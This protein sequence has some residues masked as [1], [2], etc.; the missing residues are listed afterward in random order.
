MVTSADQIYTLSREGL[1]AMWQALAGA[2]HRVVGPR[3]RDGAIVYDVLEGSRELPWGWTAQQGPAQYT[4][5]RRL[6]GAAFGWAV[7]PQSLRRFVQPA[8]ERLWTAVGS[9]DGFTIEDEPLGDD[10][11]LAFFGVRACDLAALAVQERVFIG[12][13]F[14]DVRALARRRGIFVVAVD[15]TEPGGSCFCASMQTGPGVTSGHDV[16]L[17]ERA[18]GAG[19]PVYLARAGTE[20][21][22]AWLA[23]LDF[24]EAG[25]EA[26]AE[27][28]AAVEEA[29]GRMGRSM[30]DVDLRAVIAARTE[31]RYWEEIGARCLACSNC[32]LVCPTCFCMTVEDVTDL[33]GERS[34]RH[35]RW[36]SCFGLDFSYLHGGAV[37]RAVGARYRQWMSHKLSTWWDQFGTSGCVGCG[38]CIT[39]CPVGIDITEG[40][41]R[42]AAEVNDTAG[43]DDGD[44]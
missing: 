32:T 25:D 4:L 22:A 26:V 28:R 40:A 16:A 13:E 44:P 9:S 5:E 21:G 17:T 2:G 15:C 36:D 35:R 43:E 12:G 31:S 23:G 18:G 27:G 11:P 39:W 20:R 3:V 10:A 6:D 7:G 42:L 37:R 19:G 41:A 24:A 34:E 29:S 38:R 8:R 14:V 1:E 33:A 30:P